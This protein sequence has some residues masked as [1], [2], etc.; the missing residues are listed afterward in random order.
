MSVLGPRETARR[1]DCVHPEELMGSLNAPFSAL[2]V[3][4]LRGGACVCECRSG[5][6]GEKKNVVKNGQTI[7]LKVLEN[8]FFSVE[9][10]YD[11]SQNMNHKPDG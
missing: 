8:R 1:D 11:G 9:Q 7:P 6:G 2:F 3:G 4:S 10:Q 5:A